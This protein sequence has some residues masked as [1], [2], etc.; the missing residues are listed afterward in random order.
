MRESKAHSTPI[1]LL[2]LLI[3]C[4][5]LG[6]A[7]AVV[8]LKSWF[9]G[10]RVPPLEAVGLVSAPALALALIEYLAFLSTRRSIPRWSFPLVSAAGFVIG[11]AIVTYL[12]LYVTRM[13]VFS[14][15]FPVACVI[16]WVAHRPAWSRSI[17]RTLLLV[18]L[19]VIA[20]LAPAIDSLA[21]LL[22]PSC[23]YGECMRVAGSQTAIFALLF[24][25]AMFGIAEAVNSAGREVVTFG[26]AQL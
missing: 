16:V 21:L 1:G 26:G 23:I 25:V 5:A 19:G 8:A 9:A 17:L 15:A 24:S 13:V 10:Y 3:S 20:V 11:I 12:T 2:V 4:S 18:V 22:R 7:L 6:V 14:L